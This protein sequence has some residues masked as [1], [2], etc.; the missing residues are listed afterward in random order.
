MRARY[1]AYVLQDSEFLLATWHPSTRPDAVLFTD[2]VSWNEL[3]VEE[4]TGGALDGRGTVVF[5]ARFHRGATP[6]ELY[7]RSVFERT[8]GRW[9]YL[10]GTDPQS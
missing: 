7:E 4:A 3:L 1:C 8:D 6:L 5:R 9:L 2:D 10:E